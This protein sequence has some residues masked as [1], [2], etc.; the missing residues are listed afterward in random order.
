M[1]KEGWEISPHFGCRW[2]QEGPSLSCSAA[3]AA[4]VPLSGP[5][6][7]S[8]WRENG[9][10]TWVPVS[11]TSSP[12]AWNVNRGLRDSPTSWVLMDT[13]RTLLFH[14]F[15]SAKY[16]HCLQTNNYLWCD[17]CN[18][19]DKKLYFIQWTYQN[20]CTFYEHSKSWYHQELCIYH[21]SVLLWSVKPNIT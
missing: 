21:S 16:I 7:V 19:D 11:E 12:L 1:C 18:I 15:F 5:D 6:L 9:D 13:G 2:R 14:V 4:C 8:H 20:I 3:S 17:H 10:L